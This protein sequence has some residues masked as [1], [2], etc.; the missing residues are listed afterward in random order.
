MAA[1]CRPSAP[2][3]SGPEA[4]AGS[5]ACCGRARLLGACTRGG[6]RGELADELRRVDLQAV[7][8]VQELAELGETV[9][10]FGAR[11]VI[12]QSMT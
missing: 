6:R 1:T 10:F 12:N 7:A 9:D 2:W 8:C 4:G 3:L 5:A 11:L